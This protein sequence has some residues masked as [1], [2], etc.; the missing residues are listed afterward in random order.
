M[1]DR[2]AVTTAIATRY[3]RAHKPGKATILDELCA[4]PAGIATTPARHCGQVLT[5]T[6]RRWYVP[7]SVP[8]DVRTERCCGVDLLLGSAGH[9]G[10]E[11]AGTGTARPGTHPA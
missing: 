11:A 2:R 5:P 7:D 8:T 9:A 4:R 3:K 6:V 1:T 10:R